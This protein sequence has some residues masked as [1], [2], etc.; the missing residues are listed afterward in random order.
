MLTNLE[1]FFQDLQKRGIIA[2]HANLDKFYQLKPNEKVI[3]LGIDTTAE[4]LHIGHLFLLIQTIR[5]AQEGFTVLLVLGGATSK[6]GDPSDKLKERPQLE[7]DKLK[8]FQKKITEQLHRILIRPPKREKI[9]FAPLELFYAD[10][11]KL[12]NN[13]YQ[14]LKINKE[15]KKE[16][17]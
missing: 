15:D 4:S 5:F 7:A 9:E 8:E 12:L 2:N 10:N 17:Q 16:K 14:I 1:T 6:I 11:P 13:I 3:Y